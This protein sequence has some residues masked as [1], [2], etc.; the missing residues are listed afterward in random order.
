MHPHFNLR[1]WTRLGWGALAVAG[2]LLAG[3]GLVH[4]QTVPPGWVFQGTWHDGRWDGQWIPGN[5]G[6]PDG[7]PGAIPQD[8]YA[9]SSM[10]DRE[11]QHMIN[12]C[13][14][15]HHDSVAGGA[16][17]GGVAGGVI[18]N[19]LSGGNR[20]GGTIA[21]A[22]VGG[23]AGAAIERGAKH[24]RDRDC[25]RFFNDYPEYAPDYTMQ[26]PYAAPMPYGAQMPYGAAPLGYMMVPVIPAPLAPY[27]ETK[28]VST[29][30][31]TDPRSER[32][33]RVTRAKPHHQDKRVYTGS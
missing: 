1:N 17:V 5:Q 3:S 11:T 23:V 31:V 33:Y 25:E 13:R 6:V 26:R 2:C 9:P 14:N 29:T 20:I 7:A 16:V 10:P 18:G 4:A 30:Y 21:G 19:R 15:Y 8:A 28:T 12:H 22:V 32:H 24:G 27:T